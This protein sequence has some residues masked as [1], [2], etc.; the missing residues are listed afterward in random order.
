[1]N[2]QS[3]TIQK[4][5][6]HL[7]LNA[8]IN[9]VNE[10]KDNT[11]QDVTKV[12][13]YGVKIINSGRGAKGYNEA[14][15]CFQL[16]SVIKELMGKL[17]PA[18]FMNIFPIEKDFKG[19]KW[20]MKDYFYT[21]DYINTLDTNKPIGEEILNFLMEYTNREITFFNVEVTGCLSTLRQHDGHLDI[22]EEF[23]ASQGKE[24]ENTFKNSKG[25]VLY[26]RHGK[27]EKLQK[28]KSKHLTIIK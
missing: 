9:A 22:F 3:K 5:K 23:I 16:A 2:R 6:Y 1:M 19:H 24:T 28:I 17:T 21:M 4:N 26:I 12:I 7:Y 13:F 20:E 11:D 25:E 10:Y 15:S 27:P 8:L 14:L 18:Q